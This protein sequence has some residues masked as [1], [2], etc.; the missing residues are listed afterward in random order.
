MINGIN[1]SEVA[2]WLSAVLVAGVLVFHRLS[3]RIVRHGATLTHELGHAVF[4]LFT[5]ARVTGIRLSADSSG[6]THTVRQVRVFPLGAIISSFFGYPAPILFGALF[7]SVL[8]A[9]YPT[10]AMYTIIGAGLL[11]LIFIRNLFGLLVTGT[12]IASS[13]SIYYF[14]PQAIEW[15]VLW[16]GALL[17]FAGWKDLC[18]LYNVYRTDVT[19]ST[20]LHSL[21]VSSHIHP[22]FWYALMLVVAVPVT[23]IPLFL[24]AVQA[25]LI[26]L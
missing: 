25:Q 2:V 1:Y 3:W 11:T 26:T 19:H 5:F 13:A 15:Y 17:L 20:D 12:W 10:E 18:Q 23:A 16:T 21:R 22:L 6:T 7:L 24:T 14:L 9:G 4:G 8:I